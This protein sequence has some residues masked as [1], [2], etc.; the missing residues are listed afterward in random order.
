MEPVED[1]RTP[2]RPPGLA[3]SRPHR[4]TLHSERVA[5]AP[6]LCRD[7]V[8]GV[9]RFAGLG[10]LAEVAMIC[11]SETVTNAYLHARGDTLMLRVVIRRTRVR[12]GVYD[13]CP[14][15]PPR[16]ALAAGGARFGRGLYLVETLAD[17]VGSVTGRQVG[18]Y[19]KSVWFELDTV[20]KREE[21]S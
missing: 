8:A 15:L 19:A 1:I 20:G 2:A 6:K 14:A 9:L 11:T 5:V 7:F 4:F 3:P 12:V 21:Q 16:A 13:G 18:R 10:D 17:R